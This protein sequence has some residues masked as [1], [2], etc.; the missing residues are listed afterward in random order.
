MF[1]ESLA[2]YGGPTQ[3]QTPVIDPTTDRSAAGINQALSS[4]GAMTLTA[5]TA[6][7]RFQ[8]V[9]GSPPTVGV[10]NYSAIWNNGNN[11]APTISRTSTGIYVITFPGTVYDD[12]PTQ[13]SGVNGVV[14]G[15]TPAGFNVNLLSAWGQC[16]PSNSS[17]DYDVQCVATGATITAY[18]RNASSR[19][20]AD[21]TAPFFDV[22]C[23]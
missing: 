8:I 4:V 21:P 17:D 18:V 12:I 5:V 3:D 22:F 23:R 10:I 6:W 1:N 13:L 16:C 15:S 7:V 9:T 11:P 14:P 19:A 20:L 2:Y